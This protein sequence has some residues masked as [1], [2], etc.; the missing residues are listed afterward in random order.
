MICTHKIKSPADA[1]THQSLRPSLTQIKPV[2]TQAGLAKEL[3]S[4][5]KHWFCYWFIRDSSKTKIMINLH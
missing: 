5:V 2:F 1:T 4:C 3:W